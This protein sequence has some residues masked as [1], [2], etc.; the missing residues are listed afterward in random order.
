MKE[1]RQRVKTDTYLA[2]GKVI[3]AFVDMDNNDYVYATGMRLSP[4]QAGQLVKKIQKL[5]RPLKK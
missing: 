2:R 3:I 4:K 5:L 1:K